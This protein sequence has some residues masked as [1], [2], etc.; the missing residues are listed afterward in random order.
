MPI[1]PLLRRERVS[2]S[3][4]ALDCPDALAAVAALLGDAG[5][6][7][8]LRQ[9]EQMGSTAIGH[10]IAIPHGRVAGLREPS[11][12]FLRLAKPA[13]FGEQEVDLIFA[14]LMPAENP[15]LHL[16]ALAD[17]AALFSDEHFRERLRAAPDD[18]ALFQL[19]SDGATP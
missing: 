6:F 14:L 11:G 4:R 18:D 9:R 15:Q 13:H 16:H 1:A 10:G 17:V 5:A 8:A 2:T 3:E 12:A 19:L 7:D